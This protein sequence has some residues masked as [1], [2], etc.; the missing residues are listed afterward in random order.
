MA[1]IFRASAAIGRTV[2]N[3]FQRRIRGFQGPVP[4]T[5][6]LGI[7]SWPV[8][9]VEGALPSGYVPPPDS[10]PR[11]PVSI[12]RTELGGQLPVYSE[13]RHGRSKCYTLIKHISGDVPAL[14]KELRAVLGG[15]VVETTPERGLVRIHGNKTEEVK[16]W[17]LGLG[18]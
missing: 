18:F 5:P 9:P 3:R 11:L 10:A 8:R 14:A 1:A 2:S 15:A 16:R 12:P 7:P 4:P 6:C 17:L 13:F